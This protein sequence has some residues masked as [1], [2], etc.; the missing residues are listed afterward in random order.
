MGNHRE[1]VDRGTIYHKKQHEVLVSQLKTLTKEKKEKDNVLIDLEFV[2]LKNVFL[3]QSEE[4]R[5]KT[6]EVAKKITGGQ[7]RGK[8]I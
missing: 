8:N 5:K 3:F 7:E 6:I 4:L 2:N 1:E